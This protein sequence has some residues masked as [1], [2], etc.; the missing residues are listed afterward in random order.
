MAVSAA[1]V[2]EILNRR[3]L[4]LETELQKMKENANDILS[5]VLVALGAGH[6]VWRCLLVNFCLR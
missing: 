3:V 5:K 2:N 6:E 4:P 1:D